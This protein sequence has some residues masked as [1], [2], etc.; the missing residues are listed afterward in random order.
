MAY[1]SEQNN[2]GSR[3]LRRSSDP[4]KVDGYTP[5]SSIVK[6][7]TPSPLQSDWSLRLGHAP[8]PSSN[9]LIPTRFEG[10]MI[11]TGKGVEMKT[12][13]NKMAFAA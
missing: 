13:G 5:E 12:S 9:S 8:H 2:L 3:T 4:R 10:T 1:G 6:E 7:S 11:N